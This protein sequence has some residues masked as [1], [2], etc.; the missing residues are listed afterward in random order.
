MTT[1][2]QRHNLGNV[3]CESE[4]DRLVDS[5]KNIL[6]RLSGQAARMGAGGERSQPNPAAQSLEIIATRLSAIETAVK[7]IRQIVSGQHFEKDWYTTGELAEI[8]GKSQ[9]TIQE[10]WCNEGRIECR[11]TQ[12]T[13]SGESPATKLSD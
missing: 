6:L 3:D 9:Y 12:T 5:L 2:P 8:L 7:E 11:K 13:A 4:V 1:R 10:R